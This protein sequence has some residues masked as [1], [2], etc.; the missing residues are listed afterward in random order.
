MEGDKM[1]KRVW[2]GTFSN[3]VLVVGDVEGVLIDVGDAIFLWRLNRTRIKGFCHEFSA[4]L[5]S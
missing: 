5:S 2:R 4:Y 1:K 3:P